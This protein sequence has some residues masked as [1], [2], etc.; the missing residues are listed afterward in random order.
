MKSKNI[1]EQAALEQAWLEQ[2]PLDRLPRI[3]RARGFRLYGANEKRYVDLWQAGGAAILGHNPPGVLREL[4]NTAERGLF[5]PLPTHVEGRFFKALATLLPCHSFYIYADEHSLHRAVSGAGFSGTDHS[6]RS[7]FD[8]ALGGEHTEAR[9]KAVSL[10]R[11]FLPVEDVPS[12]PLLAPVL[13][14]HLAPKTL[15]VRNGAFPF[16]TARPPA[17]D[18][19][20]PVILAAAARAVYDLLAEIGAASAGARTA[21]LASRFPVLAQAFASSAW[22]RKGVYFHYGESLDAGG[23]S[24]LFQRF[25][26]AGFLLPPAQDQ[27]AILPAVLSSGEEAKLAALVKE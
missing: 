17:S 27:P 14:W 19:V 5:A 2:A 12:C 4:K 6:I 13:P 21:R 7:I 20:S 26:E 15:A 22:R 11:P 9:E 18:A 10:W 8:P 24:A 23:Y 1:F 3:T 16:E 25:L